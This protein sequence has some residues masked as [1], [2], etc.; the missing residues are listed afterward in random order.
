MPHALT[1]HQTTIGKKVIMAVSGVI[2]V[3]FAVGHFLGNLKFLYGFIKF[4]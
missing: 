2:I 4:I 3:G 1:L